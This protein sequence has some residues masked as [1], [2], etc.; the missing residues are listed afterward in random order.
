MGEGIV[1]L[2]RG[3]TN[4]GIRTVMCLPIGVLVLASLL[5][6]QAASEWQAEVR[7]KVGAQQLDAA[8]GLAG[9][10]LAQ[11]PDD[12][13]ALGWRARILAWQGH[14]AQAESDYRAVLARVPGD[15]DMLAGL[16]DVLLWQ[17][18]DEEALATIDR[19]CVVSRQQPDLLL[20]R[21]GI[22]H[23]LGRKAEARRQLREVLAIEPGSQ[24]A[25]RGL[26]GLSEEARQELRLGI[27]V[28]TFNYTDA[29]PAQ[30]LM[31]TSRWSA[32]WSTALGAR[33]YQRFGQSAGKFVANG[34]LHVTRRDWLSIG[35]AAA[36]DE[37]II[38]KREA[39]FEYGHGF[40]VRT[41]AI[42]GVEVT[43]QQRWL[44]YQAAHVLTIGGTQTYYLPR[45]WMWTLT[46]TG[47]RSGF[48]GTGVE[49]VPSGSTRLMFPLPLRFTANLLFGVGAENFAQFDQT[50][51]FSARTYSGGLRHPLGTRQE[52][53]GYIA[54]QDRTQ[55]RT[56]TS[57]GLSYGFRF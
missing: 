35:G 12:L 33:F 2:R 20:R 37:G 5:H 43:Y 53:S 21:A 52:V 22:L 25:K 19:A 1:L 40:V 39:S 6:A 28:D 44:W 45:D 15:T 9:Q 49:W 7:E 41:R 30:S 55:G 51:R 11:A 3:I 42:R 36:H 16:A 48:R 29:A 46:L 50:G 8:L 13:E 17:G 31:L 32:R 10:R 14:W 38:P 56:Q 26:A 18:R 57:F 4:C 23:A 24:E 27:D 47:A 54:M 34:S